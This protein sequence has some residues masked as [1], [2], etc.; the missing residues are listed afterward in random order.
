[1]E[2]AQKN[3]TTQTIIIIVIV[4]VVVWLLVRFVLFKDQADQI[5]TDLEKVDQR[6][7]QFKVENTWATQEEIDTAFEQGIDGMEQRKTTYMANNPWA[8]DQEAEAAM[9]ATF[10]SME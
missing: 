10:K 1:M 5:G 3:S 2:P 9:D 6:E 8:T 7:Q 4:L